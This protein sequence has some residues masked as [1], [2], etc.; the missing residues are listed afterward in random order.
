[1]NRKQVGSDGHSRHKCSIGVS[2]VVASLDCRPQQ[3]RCS[4]WVRSSLERWG[5]FL[6]LLTRSFEV[7][8][9]PPSI[10][11]WVRLSLWQVRDGNI[12]TLKN[13]PKCI[14]SKGWHC[15][16]FVSRVISFESEGLHSVALPNG[17]R[18]DKWVSIAPIQ[19]TRRRSH[20]FVLIPEILHR[21]SWLPP[22]GS[23][24]DVFSLKT[25]R[26]TDLFAV[27]IGLKKQSFCL[28]DSNTSEI[29]W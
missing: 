10:C 21:L 9:Y 3:I 17:N 25:H 27:H 8:P 15:T 14:D 16:P 13:Q 11:G 26:I 22:E 5:R 24:A 2:V 20:W 23:G 28:S 6:G 29:P 12:D 1:M 19:N 4:E 7:P 18:I